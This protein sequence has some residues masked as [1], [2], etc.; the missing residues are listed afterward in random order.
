M[1]SERRVFIKLF[2]LVIWHSHAFEPEVAS[3]VKLPSIPCDVLGPLSSPEIVL[4]EVAMQDSEKDVVINPF[5]DGTDATGAH[6]LGSCIA[7]ETI[8]ATP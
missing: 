3:I 2:G 5:G 1:D 4:V 6:D 8:Y 7:K